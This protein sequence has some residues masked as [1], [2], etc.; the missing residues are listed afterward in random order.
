MPRSSF[1]RAATMLAAV[2]TAVALTA[3]TPTS[4]LAQ[5]A[6]GAKA[7]VYCPVGVDT[8]GCSQIVTALTGSAAFPGGVD[9]AYDGTSGTVDLAYV[10]LS[11]YAVLVVPSLADDSTHSPYAL[12]RSATVQTHLK[13]GLTGRI[14][15]WGGTPDLGSDE[16]TRPAK[17]QLLRN[18]ASWAATDWSI[19]G[20]TGLV[21]LADLSAD[22]ARRYDWLGGVSRLA[23]AADPELYGFDAATAQTGTGKEILKSGSST[24]P[25]LAYANMA[26]FGLVLPT[27][28]TMGTSDAFG[29][30]DSSGTSVVRTL[31]VTA[32][33][34]GNTGAATIKT[35]KADYAPGEIVT[36]TG[37][38]W[39]PGETVSINLH[40]NPTEHADKLLAA[41]ADSTG[42]IM[43]NQYAP[44]AHDVG[45]A[46]YVTAKGGTS[47][48]IAQT[49][50]TDGNDQKF[51]L[52][53]SPS[54]THA[55]G[56]C[57]AITITTQNNGGNATDPANPRTFNLS[58]GGYGGTFYS[59]SACTAPAI[60]STSITSPAST[61]TVYYTATVIGTPVITV[62]AAGN[63]YSPAAANT[64]TQ[65]ETL[66]PKLGFSTAART[67]A[68]AVCSAA[69]TVQSQRATGAQIAVTA[70]TSVGLTSSSGTGSFYTDAACATP[71][72]TSVTIPVGSNSATF[73]YKDATVG[74]PV[75]TATLTGTTAPSDFATQTETISAAGFALTVSTSGTGTGA[76]TS[77]PA[78][79]NCGTTCL[80]NFPA[81]SSV[82]LTESPSAGSFFGGWSGACSGTATTCSVTM[83]AAK[84]VAATFGRTTTLTVDAASGTFGGTTNLRAVL[85][86]A[87][88]GKSIAF[89]LN[90][91]SVGSAT[92]DAS[93]VATIAAAS[94][95]G[96]DAGSY[97]AG[98]GASFA[99]D[100][101]YGASSGTAALTV[102]KAGQTITFGALAAKTFGDAA[103]TVS[104]T[105]SSGLTVTFAVGAS[106]QCTIAGSTVHLTGAGSCTVT[107]SQA[108]NGNY[109]AATPV[110]RTFS[111]SPKA[112]VITPSSGQSKIFGAADPVLTFTND[113]G[114][115]AGVFTGALGR[116]VGEN[117][118]SYAINLGTLSAGANYSLSLSPTPVTFAIQPATV[119]IALSGLTGQTYDGTAK[120]ATVTASPTNAAIEAALVKT[121]KQGAT[122]VA[123]PTNAGSYALTVTSSSTNYTLAGTTTGT[124]VIGQATPTV[125]FTSTAPSTLAYNGT[126]SP[127]ATTNGDGLLTIG[128]SGACS[129]AAGVVTITAGSG[130]CTVTAAVAAGTNYG[131]ASATPQTIGATKADQVIAW[132]TPAAI[133][134]GTALS[135]TQLNAT[136]TAGDGALSYTPTA[137]TVLGAGAQTLTVN[138]AATANF[139]AA[140]K[141]VTLTVDKATLTA[142]A[143]NATRPYNTANPTL[144]GTLTGVVAGDGITVSYSTTA[145]QTS[146][147]GS[148]AIT[149]ALSDPSSK[150]GN[151]SVTLTNGTLTITKAD[152][153]IAFTQPADPTFGDDALQLTATAPGG[154]VS[155]SATGACSVGSGGAANMLSVTAA[156]SCIVTASQ[157]GD[158]NYNAAPNVSYTLTVK[159]AQPTVNVTWTGGTYGASTAANG[160]VVGVGGASL[161]TPTFSYAGTGST[162]YGPSA[163]APTN[164][165]TYAVTASF[166]GDANYLPNSATAAATIAKASSEVAV[167]C[168]ASVTYTGAA[169]TPCSATATGVSLSQSLTP[170]YTDN[171]N[172]GTAHA[173]ATFGGDAN[174]E[175]S[176]GSATFTIDR[177]ASTTVVTV[178]GATYDGA[179]HGGT[180]AVTG[181]GGLSQ[182]VP[183]T[184]AGRN[185]TSYSSSTAPTGAGDYTAS[186][187]FP[188][189]AN[190]ESS[191]D[192]QD[193]SIAKATSTVAL[194]CP[195]TPLTYT[196]AAQ[197]PCTAT[198]TGAGG[199]S[200]SLTPTYSNN[201]NAG[202]ASAS[203]SYAGDANHTGSNDAGSFTIDKANPVV[204][205]VGGSFTYT[206]APH[207]GSGSATGVTGEDLTPVTLSYSGTGGTTYG[208]SAT[209][210]TNAGTY[211]VAASYAASANYN[212]GSSS[213]VA[214]TIARA[215]LTVTPANKSKTYGD[216]FTAFDGVVTGVVSGDGITASY[217]SPGAAV[218]ATVAG[219]PYAIT[220][221]LNDPNGKLANYD[222]TLNAGTLTVD[223]KSLTVTASNRTKTYGDAVTFAGTEF[224]TPA[225]ALI[226]GDAIASV[227]LT[228]VGA[229]ATAAVA[230]SPYDIVASAATGTGLGNYDIGYTNGQLTVTPAGLTIT[231]A[232]ATRLYGDA[233]PTLSGTI[234]GI[235][236]GDGITA[237]YSTSANN[238]SPV[239]NYAIVPAAV[240]ASPAK[241]ANYAVTLTNGT[242]SVTKAPLTVTVNNKTKIQGDALPVLDGTIT[243]IKNSDQISATYATTA[244]VMSPPASYPITATLVDP[245]AKLPN[246]TVAN[247]P[248]TLTVTTNQ[249]PVITQLTLPTAP[250]QLGTA[251]PLSM[252]FTDAD[253]SAST[254][255]AL[256]I[257]WGDG[258]APTSWTETAPGT[259]SRSYQYL[260]PG[261]Y[262]VTVSVSDKVNTTPVT[263]TFQYVVVYDPN[264]GFVTGGGWINSPAGAYAPNP[265]L[266]GKATFGFVS[267]YTNG[268]TVP[269]GNTEFQFQEGSFNFKSTSYEWL[270]IAGARA[271]YK[272]SGTI[273]G[274]GDYG[275]LLTATDGDVNGGGGSDKFRMKVWNKSTG[276]II[277]D[278]QTGSS[279]TADPTTLLG[280]GSIVIHK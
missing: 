67:T 158:A 186:A 232:N 276:A 253:V 51:G 103:F 25:Y 113:G 206:G 201:V 266:A 208:P 271:Q 71:A 146:P 123:S 115:A 269:T 203:A 18:L 141:S 7:L 261:V 226:N 279:D 29:I 98:V 267:K 191:A 3:T 59:S 124:L 216:L 161:G 6:T 19:A 256:S 225:G 182:S 91:N 56:S 257:N 105:S 11:Q 62:T 16:T 205:A 244:M 102:G 128:A 264:G 107:A 118:G 63:P 222:A 139:N 270:T 21:V 218:T 152:Q 85:T 157:A 197:T 114:L 33:G 211:A 34:A 272:G 109:S 116:A 210:P 231:A 227:T 39:T 8:A 76:V 213:A 175:G 73:Y 74:S 14:A 48:L 90:G 169:L 57:V 137:G 53:P 70:A 131:A 277:Y 242:L 196:G 180:A 150:L 274:S 238:A 12:L 112:V 133:A 42:A 5:T 259:I 262:S 101:G 75:V 185:G 149:P 99:G 86:P 248:G 110:S 40:E 235:K 181:A 176:T 132:A 64:V 189:D 61:A 10:T 43:N 258:R 95:A 273:N 80:A 88:I 136:L 223:R 156:G 215:A 192:A 194:V 50:F 41:V 202:T 143:D 135:A 204:A 82:T 28:A 44:E 78:G 69:I 172:A 46:Y 81:G 84:S 9:R 130:T 15:V 26:S 153:T 32:A 207:A 251:V 125:S 252:T 24:T 140:S 234:A 72:V 174:H 83:D 162:T 38:G 229:V 239:G 159:K 187:S 254:P 220:A 58:D 144:T 209:A 20:T 243:G 212:A 233:N 37:T 195:T 30:A 170:T 166:A 13:A 167:T 165:G 126:Y 179:P 77:S 275:F 47:G 17:D 188:G 55:V 198:V 65:T 89:T 184:Y 160:S 168:P 245:T 240:D 151:Y 36:F 52:T 22:A 87:V 241:L 263:R 199:L 247:T 278:N 190:H 117:V 121:Y 260:T 200:Q 147:V 138:A 178:S 148:Y 171:T 94:L 221:T 249:P 31:L 219:S 96:I 66:V 129:Y 164:A 237:T 246:Y 155:F 100:A 230:G 122:V 54:F 217:T 268:A 4:A 280:G 45:V 134:Y 265:A 154:V 27:S 108:G 49:S 127:T 1:A 104:A 35:D 68:S 173:S 236:N 142:V 92:T 120:F 250:V 106:D 60:T 145:T 214:L 111:I 228:S 163:T 255:Y 183:V 79:I 97:A 193:F 119:T 2:L 224:T 23:L 177:A 93:G